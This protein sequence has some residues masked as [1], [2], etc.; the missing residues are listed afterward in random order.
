MRNLKERPVTISE[1]ERCLLDFADEIE[2]Q[3]MGGDMRPELLRTA[4]K[5]VVFAGVDPSADSNACNPKE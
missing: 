1:I 2:Q 5:L 4:A 3:R